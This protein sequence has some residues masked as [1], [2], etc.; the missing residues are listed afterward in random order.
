MLESMFI[1]STLEDFDSD[2]NIVVL[3][4]SRKKFVPSVYPAGDFV[5]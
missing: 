5:S 1:N 2:K 4:T 3:R